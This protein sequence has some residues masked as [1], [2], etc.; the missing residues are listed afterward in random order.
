MDGLIASLRLKV[1]ELFIFHGKKIRKL[2]LDIVGKHPSPIFL[3]K[4]GPI[5]LRLSQIL[6]ECED[7][8]ST[9]PGFDSSEIDKLAFQRLSLEIFEE[10]SIHLQ[11]CLTTLKAGFN[12]DFRKYKKIISSKSSRHAMCGQFPSAES[13]KDESE[14]LEIRMKRLI[15]RPLES[16]DNCKE[17]WTQHFDEYY[18][19]IENYQSC[20]KKMNML[21]DESKKKWTDNLGLKLKIAGFVISVAS[22][23]VAAVAYYTK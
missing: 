23:G 4:M 11:E 7:S 16:I 9:N 12:E 5:L 10:Y 14:E 13:L 8:S 6:D 20:I 15:S 18:S 19:L 17:N 2:F 3:W 1:E 22:I 21:F